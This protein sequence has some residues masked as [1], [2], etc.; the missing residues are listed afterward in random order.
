M[1]NLSQRIK[2]SFF[3]KVAFI[4][5]ML[6]TVSW[7]ALN[8]KTVYGKVVASA[9]NEPLIGATVAIQGVQNSGVITDYDGKFSIEAKDGQTLVVSYIG[10]VT[11]T[12]RVAG[13]NLVISLDSE[14]QALDEVVVIGYGTQR[15][16]A[17]TGSVASVSSE[18]LMENPSSNI[19]Q[20]LQNR[21]AGVDMQQT[22]SQPGAEMQIRIRG[23]RS[24]SA[25]NDPL[26]VL[27]GIPFLGNLSDINPSDIKS[28]DILKD[29]SA[30]AIYGSRG[31][32]GVIIITTNKGHMEMPAKVTYNGYVSLKTLFNPF[33]MMKGEKYT[34]MRKL[35]GKFGNG[36]DEHEGNDTDWQ[37]LFYK[38]GLSHSHNVTVSGGS[39]TG[40]YSFGG[41]YNRDEG[42]IPT[43]SFD[44]ITLRANIEQKVGEIFKLGLSSTNTYNQR[45]GMHLGM[46]GI[47]QMTPLVDPNNLADPTGR[48]ARMSSD[49]VWFIT[50]DRIEDN[51]D[52]WLQHNNT[53]ATYN[54][55]FGEI[56][57]P[58]IDG[59]KYRL[60]L[61]LN[62]RGNK[63]GGFTGTGINTVNATEL[64][65]ASMQ[66]SE[67]KNYAVENILSYDKSF[68]KHNI[69][70]VGLY[71]VEQTRYSTNHM[72]SRGV[73]EYFQYWNIGA[74]KQ[75]VA[76]NPSWQNYWQ[77]GLMSWMGRLMYNYDDR[78][79]ISAAVRSDA[80]SRLA[81]GHQWH[82]YPA[83]SIGWN[84]AK[85]AFMQNQ[86]VVDN[87]KLRAGYGQTA[88]Q[89]ISPYTTLGN[90]STSPY[91]F[92]DLGTPSYE[93]G[94]YITK[95]PNPE[96]GWEY[97]ET[98]NFGIDF[99]LF[100]GRL[101][102]TVEYY[103]QNT[104][105]ILLNVSLPSTSGVGSYTANI[106]KTQNKG[107][108]ATLNGVI[109]NN[110]N[111][112][113]WEAGVNLA[114]NRN[115]L[116]AL[117]DGSEKDEANGW[118][119][120]HPIDV[121]YDYEKVGLWNSDD[122]D[123]A[124]FQTLEPGGNEGMIKVKYEKRYNDK[125]ELQAIG[126]NDRQIISLE[127]NFV[128]GFNT[129]VA[130]KGFDLNVIGAFQCGGKL[131]S[132][133]YGSSGYLNM[134]T[135]RRGQVDVD[136]WT[137]DNKGAKYPKPGG[138]QSG[139]NPKYGS[140]LGIFDGSYVKIRTISLG[141]NFSGKWMKT[142]GIEN[143][144]LYATVQNPFIIYSPYWSE[145]GLD[146][147]PNSMSNQGQF[148][149][150]QIGGHALPV[151]GTNA[152]CTRNY[153]LGL[154][155]TLGGGK[156]KAAKRAA[157]TQV[158]EKVVEK[159]VEKPVVKEVVKEVV[160]TEGVQ[161]T[162]IVTFP[163]SSSEIVNKAELDGIKAG[164]SVEIVAYASPEG[165]AD[166]N[167][168]LSQQRADAVASYLKSRGVNVTRVEAKGADTNH[169]NRIAIVTI[170]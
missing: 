140:T 162:Y 88:N 129:R 109:I 11:K 33:P 5:M 4:A 161:S 133:L 113:T 147:E 168:T 39:S 58:G 74:G 21:I 159:I 139:D 100:K 60:N 59:L 54:T 154:N 23:Q 90:L 41:S 18:K 130:Y 125:G 40:T 124:D 67:Y 72:G 9:D 116:V 157:A 96:L 102:G 156:V 142:A 7:G 114:L 112:W 141:Y 118:F 76:V 138:I 45:N 29:A 1:G 117:A 131:I 110:K 107:L 24:L 121:L 99:S 122:P 61:G 31:A 78:Y 164:Q 19:T 73:P 65:S 16:E 97:S 70:A 150:T 167:A 34:E 53:L 163:L 127:P 55:V 79:M 137:E 81:K 38:N 91:N 8:A 27:D 144:R 56:Y 62:Y 128:G 89:A 50:R 145:S 71:S 85:E 169:A 126:P 68:G 92:G 148:H 165:P 80:S 153:L 12:V 84:I 44:R 6:L 13:N 69:S 94:Y 103:I 22:N 32:N 42:V 134:L 3:G 151:V 123:W 36:I 106:G 119:V 95:L 48:I 104:N 115:K 135:G 25:S 57:F 2:T 51:K 120:G 111:G 136:Y 93:T 66:Q 155:V 105:D 26:I 17:V 30:T 75:D 170:K 49:D 35:A 108:E 46:Y 82:T 10:F 87:L 47:L 52:T 77:A 86:E 166:V 149:A 152:P 98:Y 101:S 143:L 20:A 28:L 43:Q 14:D 83:V 15:K 146:P 160:K 132:T 158:V 64:N 37:D 63:V